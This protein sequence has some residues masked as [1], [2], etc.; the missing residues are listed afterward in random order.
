MGVKDCMKF[1]AF[2]L[3]GMIVSLFIFL[4]WR[5][6]LHLDY[7]VKLYPFPNPGS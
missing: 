6:C 1:K 7:F 5:F 2:T 3:E 4:Q